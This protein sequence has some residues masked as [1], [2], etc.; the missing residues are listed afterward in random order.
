MSESN[1]HV[2]CLDETLQNFF[3]SFRPKLLQD[4]VACSKLVPLILESL[5]AGSVIDHITIYD[6]FSVGSSQISFTEKF[7]RKVFHNVWVIKTAGRNL[8][9]GSELRRSARLRLKRIGG[10][11]IDRLIAQN[12]WQLIKRNENPAILCLEDIL[13]P[14][15]RDE[16]LM[17]KKQ[18]IL[19]NWHHACNV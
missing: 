3:T 14:T 7:Y 12:T 8:V 4:K 15:V 13:G 11:H 16:E 10:D 9:Y 19:R 5:N 2:A 6:N 17:K 18:L 1:V